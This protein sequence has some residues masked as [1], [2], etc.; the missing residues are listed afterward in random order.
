[1]DITEKTKLAQQIAADLLG[2]LFAEDQRL[3]DLED[4]DREDVKQMI[5]DIA[6]YLDD[7]MKAEGG[8]LW[9]WGETL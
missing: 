6:N 2:N 8:N 3:D 4:G 5:L 1:M 7:T 9:P